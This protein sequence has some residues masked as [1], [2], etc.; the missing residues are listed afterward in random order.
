M[1]K[2]YVARAM[3]GRVKEEVVR[4]AKADKEYLEKLGF[5]VLDPVTSENVEA[6]KDILMSP[7]EIMDVYWPRDKAM[8]REAHVVFNMSPHTA[9]LGVMREHGYARYHLWKKTVSVF[10]AGKAPAEGAIAYYEDD[11][12]TDHILIA[13]LDCLRSHGTFWRRAKWRLTLFARCL[14][15]A[16]WHHLKEWK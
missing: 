14:P 9:S 3:S 2:V 8:I 13:A 5:T 4:E 15:K 12:V 1:I 16:I 6:T 11:L 7:K 10:P